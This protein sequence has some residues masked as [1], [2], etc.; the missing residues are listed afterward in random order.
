MCKKINRFFPCLLG[1]FLLGSIAVSYIMSA[2]GVELPYWQQCILSELLL[3]VPA[4]IYVA[5]EKIDVMACIPY[6]K[7][8]WQDALLSIL[9]GYM[10]IP[11]VLFINVLTSLFA[12]NY[13]QESSV[14]FTS[15]P[16]LV[17]VLLIAVLPAA[18]EEFVF[19]GLIYHSY[20]RN[21]LVGAALFSALAFGIMH[22]NLNQFFYAFIIGIF[23]AKMVEVTGTMWSSMFAHFAFNTYSITMV[24]LLKMAGVDAYAETSEYA[25]E[26]AS[27]AS[28]VLADIYQVVIFGVIA[29]LFLFLANKIVN[30]MAKKNGRYEYYKYYAGMGLTEMNGERFVTVPYAATVILA[31]IYMIV[32]EVF[33]RL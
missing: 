16:Y 24:Q 23:F 31:A 27:A 17:Q 10:L 25:A 30:H 14:E 22:M 2:T 29:V 21:G 9:V 18:V 13:L 32:I 3:L 28:S 5:I 1:F 8:R 33:S 20:R 4:F 15:Y 19:R 11:V 12:T 6:R 7:I 26:T